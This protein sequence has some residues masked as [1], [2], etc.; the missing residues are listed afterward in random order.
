MFVVDNLSLPTSSRKFS[1]PQLGERRGQ[2]RL[3]G[4]QHE[5]RATPI[6]LK[7]A[8]WAEYD[9]AT[10][11]AGEASKCCSDVAILISRDCRDIDGRREPAKLADAKGPLVELNT[12]RASVCSYEKELIIG[13]HR[14][15]GRRATNQRQID[16]AG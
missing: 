11:T 1:V 3:Y 15:P 7:A 13:C 9:K 6:L 12:L 5:V 14:C 10:V 4:I 8:V 16:G 2:Y